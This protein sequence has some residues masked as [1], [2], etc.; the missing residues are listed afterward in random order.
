MLDRMRQPK[1]KD[2]DNYLGFLKID[3]NE[4]TRVTATV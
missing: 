3:N 1:Y 2:I 4:S